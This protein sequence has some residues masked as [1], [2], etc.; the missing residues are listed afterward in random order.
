MSNIILQGNREVN[1][2]IR[3]DTNERAMVKASSKFNA[4][5]KDIEDREILETLTSIILQAYTDAGQVVKG[6]TKAEQQLS[7]KNFALSLLSDIREYFKTITLQEVEIAIRNGVRKM[8][9]EYMGLNVV[10]FHGFIH[11]YKHSLERTEALHKQLQH[12]KENQQGEPALSEQ[13]ADKLMDDACIEAF[14]QYKRTGKLM[15][16]GSVKYLHLEK[17]GII[18]YDNEEKQEILEAAKK[19]L[20]AERSLT[21]QGGSLHDIIQAQK[22]V[23]IFSE[24]ELRSMARLVALERFFEAC[25]ITDSDLKAEI[26]EYNSRQV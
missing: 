15:D 14:E 5:T 6:E 21:Q 3:L 13:E 4:M 22:N 20:Q 11:A 10:S 18:T 25:K 2:S 9:G 24:N 19:R 7:I 23:G 17:K 16:W 8:Y 12:E 26:E 1:L